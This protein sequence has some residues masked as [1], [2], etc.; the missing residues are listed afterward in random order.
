M[1]VAGVVESGS[2]DGS[3]QRVCRA[4][5]VSTST[6]WRWSERKVISQIF[7]LLGTLLMKTPAENTPPHRCDF[8]KGD[9]GNKWFVLASWDVRVPRHHNSKETHHSRI[10]QP[11][12][13]LR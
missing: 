8:I 4:H 2:E 11:R 10:S 9:W 13:W 1:A 3:R 12:G 7:R 6:T 5:S